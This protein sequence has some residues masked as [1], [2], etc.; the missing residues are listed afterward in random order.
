[1]KSSSDVSGLNVLADTFYLGS[2]TEMT[3]CPKCGAHGFGFPSV[4]NNPLCPQRGTQLRGD[5]AP[6]VGIAFRLL[7][8]AVAFGTTLTRTD[9]LASVGSSWTTIFGVQIAVILLVTP[10]QI[11]PICRTI[12]RCGGGM[13][14]GYF[15][16]PSLSRF[17]GDDFRYVISGSIIGWLVGLAYDQRRLTRDAAENGQRNGGRFWSPGHSVNGEEDDTKYSKGGS[18]CSY[19]DVR[20]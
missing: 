8:A 11:G 3:I 13:L 17:A 12:L 19:Y 5:F 1:M 15:L 7:L 9:L 18:L 14:F 2:S 4:C 6:L 10:G 16:C 20:L